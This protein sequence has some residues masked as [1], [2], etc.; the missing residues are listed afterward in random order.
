M[1]LP[2]TTAEPTTPEPPRGP[3][4]DGPARGR[5]VEQFRVGLVP[6]TSA[7]PAGELAEQ[8]RKR[9]RFCAVLVVAYCTA[10]LGLLLPLSSPRLLAAPL[11]AFTRQPAYGLVLL[12]GC[13]EGALAARLSPRRP[14]DLARLRALEWVALAPVLAYSA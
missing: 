12:I 8:L 9:L 5:P 6:H 2:R 13:L 10:E 7:Q 4:G 11:E 14:A 1:S 3:R